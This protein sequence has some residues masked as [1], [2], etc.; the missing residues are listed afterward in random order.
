[1]VWCITQ[2]CLARSLELSFILYCHLSNVLIS[3]QK[4]V[5]FV[6]NRVIRAGLHQLIISQLKFYL[7]NYTDFS[8][9]NKYI[10]NNYIYSLQLHVST[11]MSHLQAR[12]IFVCDVTVLV[13]GS[14]KFT[15]FTSTVTLQTNIVLAWR[16]LMWVETCSCK[17]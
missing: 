13:L 7:F 9:H 1:M 14:Q 8:Q 3:A 5:L 6:F 17:L 10:N 15:C 16:W 12:T 4:T 11:H 2:N